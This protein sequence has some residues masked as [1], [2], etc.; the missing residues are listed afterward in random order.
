MVRTVD[1]VRIIRELVKVI[2]EWVEPGDCGCDTF[3]CMGTC[4]PA[5]SR[6]VVREALNII[7]DTDG[8]V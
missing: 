8:E 1:Y 5:K 3:E 6:D 4:L 7:N 2:E